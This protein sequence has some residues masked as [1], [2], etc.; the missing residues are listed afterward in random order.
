YTSVIN[1]ARATDFTCSISVVGF[2][3]SPYFWHKKSTEL[4]FLCAV[5][6]GRFLFSREFKSFQYWKIPI[7]HLQNRTKKFCPKKAKK[8]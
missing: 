7:F 6:G 8:P 5:C 4:F 2:I 3:V 1:R